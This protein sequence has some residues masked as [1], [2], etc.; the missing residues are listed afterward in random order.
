MTGRSMY[1]LRYE[2]MAGNWPVL[3]FLCMMCSTLVLLSCNPY[4]PR[5]IEFVL[6]LDVSTVI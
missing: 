3:H 1:T 5:L 6:T 4:P 2:Q